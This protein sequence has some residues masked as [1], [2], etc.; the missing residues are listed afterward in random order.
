MDFATLSPMT[1]PTE[2]L[3]QELLQLPR[4]VRARL[5]EVLVQSVERDVAAAWD[6][7]AERRYQA[8]L[9][10]E[11]DAHP[12]REALAALRAKLPK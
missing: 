6:A 11:I 5:A 10:G 2:Q 9:R 1:I 4:E 7:E 3:E 12:A 8:Y